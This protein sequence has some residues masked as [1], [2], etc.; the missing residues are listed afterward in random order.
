MNVSFS[1]R[2]I[3]LAS[4]AYIIGGPFRLRLYYR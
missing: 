3:E 2:R 1:R 4:V